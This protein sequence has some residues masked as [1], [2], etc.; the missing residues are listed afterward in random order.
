MIEFRG[1]AAGHWYR[2]AASDALPLSYRI[3]QIVVYR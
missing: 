2:S 3:S 1:S